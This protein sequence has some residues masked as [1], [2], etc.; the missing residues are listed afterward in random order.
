MIVYMAAQVFTTHAST[1]ESLSCSHHVG[2][3]RGGWGLLLVATCRAGGPSARDMACTRELVVL[4]GIA[5]GK[6]D[7]EGMVGVVG[8]CAEDHL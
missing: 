5:E 7:V 3:G 4:A 8:S 2:R 6:D 1:S